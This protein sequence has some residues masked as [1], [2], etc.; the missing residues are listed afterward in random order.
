[1][2]NTQL[3]TTA[4]AQGG[5]S[6]SPINE[7]IQAAN[8]VAKSGLFGI[9][10][11]DQAATLMMVAQSEG[12]HFMT[13]LRDYHVIKGKPSLKADAMLARFQKSGGSVKWLARTDKSCKAVFSHPQ[14]SEI[15]VEWDMARAEKTGQTSK[16]TWKQYPAQML[17]ARCV[18]E[19]VRAIYPACINGFYTPE[20]VM[21]FSDK[22]P[23]PAEAEAIGKRLDK[24]ISDTAKALETPAAK[25]PADDGRNGFKVDIGGAAQAG[26]TRTYAG[27]NAG[28]PK[29]RTMTGAEKRNLYNFITGL[30][31]K[32]QADIIIRKYCDDPKDIYLLGEHQ[33]DNLCGELSKADGQ[34]YTFVWRDF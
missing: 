29:A 27:A 1:M 30:K 15:T 19:G 20:E 6:L 7:I 14:G 28:E 13:A 25:P 21:D 17:A 26:G 24:A 16:D 23:A 31:N 8:I 5:N 18:S 9:T 34:T 12:T 10:N 3:A 32:S 22:D 2:S 4:Q 11:A 33:L